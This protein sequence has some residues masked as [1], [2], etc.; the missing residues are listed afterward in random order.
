MVF[1]PHGW[2]RLVQMKVRI[3]SFNYNWKF[4]YFFPY[5]HYQDV[6]A[7]PA[8]VIIYNFHFN[9][10]HAPFQPL[11]PHQEKKRNKHQPL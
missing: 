11:H 6:T 2:L 9:L 10:V 5:V 7:P 8:V 3:A 1:A 4:L